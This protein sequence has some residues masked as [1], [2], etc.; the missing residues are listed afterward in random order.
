LSIWLRLST[1]LLLAGAIAGFLSWDLTSFSQRLR[2][3]APDDD[4][5]GLERK[6][7]L[8]LLVV[9]LAGLVLYL[10]ALY[11][12]AKA[13]FGWSLLLVLLGVWG[14]GRVVNWLLRNGRV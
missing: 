2:L 10:G 5:T 7:L 13:S 6:H 9:A 12:Q 8:R 1:G 3:S 11:L 4:V 14:I